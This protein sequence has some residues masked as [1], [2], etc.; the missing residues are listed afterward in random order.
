ME[1]GKGNPGVFISERQRLIDGIE[2]ID[3]AVKRIMEEEGR[4]SVSERNRD[5]IETHLQDIRKLMETVK[6]VDEELV[7]RVGREEEE[8]K[9][10]LL[11]MQN[12]RR[13]VSGYQRMG[14]SAPRFFDKLR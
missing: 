1:E 9:R 4:R 2:K 5:K 11:K 7:H 14:K 6:S 10:S 8:A 3:S 13:A 12:A